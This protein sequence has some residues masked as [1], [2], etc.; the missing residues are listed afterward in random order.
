MTRNLLVKILLPLGAWACITAAA[1]A[2]PGYQPSPENLKARREFQDDK[3]GLFI[4]WGVYS[5]LGDGEWVLHN[6]KLELHD[7]ERL[8]NFFDPE[9]FDARAWVALAKAAGMRYITITSRHH[10]GFAMFDSKVSDW[11][12]VARTPYQKDPLK[13]LADE[14]HRQASSSSSTIRSSTGITRTTI[15]AAAPRGTTGAP[16]TATGTRT[17]TSTWTDSFAN[18]S[19]TTARSAASGSTACGTSPTPTGI[20]T[21]PTP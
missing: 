9:K 16:S 18:S 10:D 11:N 17:S 13:M 2:Q 8:P 6:R 14:A 5:V 12:I 21:K 7:Y 4:H 20:S 19:P 3:F 1:A 15:P